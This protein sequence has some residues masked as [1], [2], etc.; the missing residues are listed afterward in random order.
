MIAQTRIDQDLKPVGLDWITA[1]RDPTNRMLALQRHIQPSLF[2][3][4]DI[5]AVACPAFPGER[6]LSC[7]YPVVAADYAASKIDRDE[8]DRRPGTLRRRKMVKHFE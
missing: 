6:L 1:Q 7:D 2:D 3:S 4:R 8:F 5:A